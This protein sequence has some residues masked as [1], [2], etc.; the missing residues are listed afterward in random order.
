LIYLAF[1]T[2]WRSQKQQDLRNI[3]LKSK[4]WLSSPVPPHSSI[5][6]RL[7]FTCNLF[8]SSSRLTLP[9]LSRSGAQLAP[10][11]GNWSWSTILQPLDDLPMSLSTASFE[12]RNLVLSHRREK[13]SGCSSVYIARHSGRTNQCLHLT[14]DLRYYVRLAKE[15]QVNQAKILEYLPPD[16]SV[17]A[18]LDI[19][20]LVLGTRFHHIS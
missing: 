6:R 14:W 15:E 8:K 4:R 10:R 7:S 20:A 13:S 19:F 11:P 12:C 2:S 16:V 17:A 9:Y 1:L 18:M 5:K 3:P